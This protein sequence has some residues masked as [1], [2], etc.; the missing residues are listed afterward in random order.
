MVVADGIQ[1]LR[2]VRQA[3]SAP[4]PGGRAD[5]EDS[6]NLFHRHFGVFLCSFAAC[7]DA[8]PITTKAS[9]R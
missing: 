9:V 5:V 7:S 8:K 6:A 1:R 3:A 4:E 2:G